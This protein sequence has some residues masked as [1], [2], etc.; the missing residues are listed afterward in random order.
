MLRRSKGAVTAHTPPCSMP[1]IW[2]R[3]RR[4][5]F[6]SIAVVVAAFAISTSALCAQA[7]SPSPVRPCGAA[8]MRQVGP[9]HGRLRGFEGG[10]SHAAVQWARRQRGGARL[11]MQEP[12]TRED[13][14]FGG[15]PGVGALRL[16]SASSSS[17][18][19]ERTK[20][21]YES[22]TLM[23]E[24]TTDDGIPVSELSSGRRFDWIDEL[25]TLF[26]S[27]VLSRIV[28]RMAFT[29][30]WAIVVTT[31]ITLGARYPDMGLDFVADF[32]IPGWPHELVGGFL[33][34]LLVFR[35]DQ[36]YDRFWEGRRQWA[37]LSM[38]CR[39][40]GRVSMSNLQGPM[41][42]ITHLR[43]HPC[44]YPRTRDLPTGSNGVCV[45]TH[46]FSWSV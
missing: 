32:E 46:V 36:A 9:F 41:V 20:Q 4:R 29:I 2:H 23:S 21:W 3:H 15:G 18:T 28:N 40:L 14:K 19:L 11:Q 35:T 25:L 44:T 16:K 34:I 12:V 10:P 39:D 33:A 8:L 1:C 22:S 6:R 7:F 37:E 5:P 13:A 17:K 26:N 43:T 42:S 38:A 30:A 27:R 24:L 31:I 45:R